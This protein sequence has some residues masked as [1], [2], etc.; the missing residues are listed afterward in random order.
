MDR[1]TVVDADG[2]GR[3]RPRGPRDL[4]DRDG[5]GVPDEQEHGGGLRR[6]KDRIT[7]G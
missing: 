3:H 7:A 5:D 1:E 4:V 2:D 6:L